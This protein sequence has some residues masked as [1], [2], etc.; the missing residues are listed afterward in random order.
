MGKIPEKISPKI[1]SE[2]T[3][4]KNLGKKK[5]KERLAIYVKTTTNETIYSAVKRP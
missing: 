3:A 1:L 4:G 5:N 2:S